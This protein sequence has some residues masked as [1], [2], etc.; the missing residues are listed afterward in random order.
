MASVICFAVD[1]VTL[2]SV[3]AAVLFTVAS[4]AAA[5]SAS[6]LLPF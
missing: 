5:A 6:L 2:G 3:A 4:A 1:I